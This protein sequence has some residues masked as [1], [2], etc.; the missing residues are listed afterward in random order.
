M[1]YFPEEAVRD[2]V[3]KKSFLFSLTPDAKITVR[4]LKIHKKE[5]RIYKH[6]VDNSF[7][8]SDYS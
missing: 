5:K 2:G 8:P 6:Y 1:D 4:R 7:S 3:V